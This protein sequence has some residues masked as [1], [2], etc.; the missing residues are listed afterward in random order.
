MPGFLG[1]SRTFARHWRK[2]IEING[3]TLRVRGCWRPACG[4]SS[5]AG[6]RKTWP[7]SCRR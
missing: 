3:E 6:A 5:C 1:D 4:R 2:P 7:P